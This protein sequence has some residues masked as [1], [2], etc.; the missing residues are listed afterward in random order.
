MERSKKHFDKAIQ[1]VRDNKTWSPAE[2]EVAWEFIDR[3]RC[4]IGQASP[5]IAD[6][7]HDL[8]EEYGQDNDL[9]EGWWYDYADEDEIFTQ[10]L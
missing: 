7:I 4:P 10:L 5:R 3:Y 9:P 1:Y 6:I 8:M 2:E